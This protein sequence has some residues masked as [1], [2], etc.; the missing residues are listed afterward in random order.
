MP[1][2]N[3]KALIGTA[4][5][6]S[7]VD[8]HN[9]TILASVHKN[10]GTQIDSVK[11]QLFHVI[12]TGQTVAFAA[13]PD[14]AIKSN[15]AY[16]SCADIDVGNNT[17]LNTLGIGNGQFIAYEMSWRGAKAVNNLYTDCLQLWRVVY[18]RIQSCKHECG[19]YTEQT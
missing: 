8:L 10:N 2:G 13:L 17:A 19:S 18:N 16:F 12:R 7:P 1:V 5:N 3:D 9:V 4:K 15:I 6:V 11:S 14:P